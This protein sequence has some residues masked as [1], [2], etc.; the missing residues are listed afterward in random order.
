MGLLEK[1]RNALARPRA[2]HD[3]TLGMGLR[4]FFGL[5]ENAPPSAVSESTYFTCMKVLAETMG[6]LPLKYYKEDERGGMVRAPTNAAARLL[7]TRPNEVMTPAAFWS[8]LELNCQH[9]GNAYAY[10]HGQASTAVST[11]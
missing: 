2:S 3:L 5:D 10:I 7:L 4:E 8:T 1:I 9:Y 6:K 11:S